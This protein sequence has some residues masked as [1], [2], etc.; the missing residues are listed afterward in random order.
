MGFLLSIVQELYSM[1]IEEPVRNGKRISSVITI[2]CCLHSMIPK[3]IK[4]DYIHPDRLDE[5]FCMFWLYADVQSKRCSDW[6][7]VNELIPGSFRK[8]AHESV[9]GFVIHSGHT[10]HFHRPEWLY[11]IPIVHFLGGAAKPFQA[12]EFNPHE[13]PW[14]DKLIGLQGMRSKTIDK[15][16]G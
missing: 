15:E 11:A 13:I 9:L 10:K 7:I 1:K 2:L 4:M 12:I 6:E 5:V 8:T 3:S 14:G 16:F